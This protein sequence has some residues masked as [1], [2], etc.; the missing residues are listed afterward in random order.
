MSQM[1]SDSPSDTYIENSSHFTSVRLLTHYDINNHFSCVCAVYQYK[2][3]CMEARVCV[4]FWTFLHI[5]HTLLLCTGLE[6]LRCQSELIVQYNIGGNLGLN[7]CHFIPIRTGNCHHVL[8]QISI[9]SM[10]RWEIL[11]DL[12]IWY[13]IFSIQY[14]HSW[15][16]SYVFVTL[17]I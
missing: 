9:N 5:W 8:Q 13:G 16:Y 15:W 6:E 3:F 12:Y 14:K 11:L 17:R 4:E 7:K 1:V 10:G 2:G